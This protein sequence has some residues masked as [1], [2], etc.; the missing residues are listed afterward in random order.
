MFPRDGTSPRNWVGCWTSRVCTGCPINDQGNP[1]GC[2]PP[3][4]CTHRQNAY[5]SSY[6][7]RHTDPTTSHA[8]VHAK[9]RQ[10]VANSQA[11]LNNSAMRW[12][13]LASSPMTPVQVWTRNRSS[14]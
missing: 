9:A 14:T 5:T 3:R 12:V 11:S 6:T 10:V 4:Q 13:H 2:K 8:H 1:L 7:A